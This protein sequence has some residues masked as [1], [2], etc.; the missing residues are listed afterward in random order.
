MTT[1]PS[2]STFSTWRRLERGGGGAAKGT[3]RLYLSITFEDELY[4]RTVRTIHCLAV[5]QL[6]LNDMYTLLE[7]QNANGAIISFNHATSNGRVTDG[8]VHTWLEA[9]ASVFMAEMR[10]RAQNPIMLELFPR[11]TPFG[12]MGDGSNDHSLS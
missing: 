9:G 8:G 11:G 10:A 2:S 1:T 4:A 3:S 7:L 12:A 5:R 6:S